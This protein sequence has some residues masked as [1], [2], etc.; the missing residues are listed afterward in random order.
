MLSI[1][2][3]R[4]FALLWWGGMLSRTGTCMLYAALPYFVYVTSRSVTASGAAVISEILPSIVFNTVGG[5][6]ADRLPRKAVM[7]LGR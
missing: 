3:Q 1:L 2:K 4:N 7:A 6:F 5:V